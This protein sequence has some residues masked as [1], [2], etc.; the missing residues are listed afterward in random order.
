LKHKQIYLFGFLAFII[1]IFLSS[2]TNVQ[3]DLSDP[4]L[5]AQEFM[6]GQATDNRRL[7][8]AV[9]TSD[10][11]KRFGEQNLFLYDRESISNGSLTKSASLLAWDEPNKK[12][13]QINY[14]IEYEI[15][16]KTM[17][18]ELNEAISLME[19][20]NNWYIDDYVPDRK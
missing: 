15:D 20:D 6:K 11:Q 8:N 18:L 5:V 12:V 4:K 2:C 1:L 14:S 16:G 9:L 17:V 13:Y 7:V 3:V 10:L 19:K